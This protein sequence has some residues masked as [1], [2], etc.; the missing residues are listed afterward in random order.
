MTVDSS[1][2]Q[3]NDPQDQALGNRVTCREWPILQYITVWVDAPKEEEGRRRRLK[4]CR[5]M[6]LN[7]EMSL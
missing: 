5:Q 7:T 2:G 3:S 6:G 1:F 4:I